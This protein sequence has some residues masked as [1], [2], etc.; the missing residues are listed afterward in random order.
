MAGENAYELLV[1][2]LPENTKDEDL[3][4]FYEQWGV[5]ERVDIIRHKDTKK[6]RGFAFVRFVK[7]E[8][9]N[10]AMAARPHELDGT[11]ITPHRSAPADYAKKLESR[12]TCNELY[13]GDVKAEITEA[14][15]RSHFENYGNVGEISI[16]QGKNGELRGFA[17][18]KF[19]DHDPVDICCYKK[20]HYIKDK[21]HFVSKYIDKKIMNDLK[22]KYER[23]DNNDNEE[24]QEIDQRE[25]LKEVLK[26]Q[27]SA[28]GNDDS[29]PPQRNGGPQRKRNRNE[30]WM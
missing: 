18:V 7:L 11:K 24:S 21:R 3:K 10:A 20:V 30:E 2:H 12:H 27:L 22:W 9:V 25:L 23:R 28:L 13:V 19:D 14:D 5:V 6:S 26:A 8:S 17:V 29:G 1:R 16:P 15:L 4:T